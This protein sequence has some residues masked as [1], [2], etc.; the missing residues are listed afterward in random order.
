MGDLGEYL[1]RA[2][3]LSLMLS[4]RIV[5]GTAVVTVIVAALQVMSHIQD[6][7]LSHLPRLLIAL[8]LLALT[9]PW[10]LDH[11]S[12][13]SAEVWRLPLELSLE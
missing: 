9:G 10:I 3:W 4:M 12:H 7:T 8:A 13:F 5:L 6:F 1:T 11:L 2:L